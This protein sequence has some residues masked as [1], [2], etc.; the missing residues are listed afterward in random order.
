MKFTV[1]KLFAGSG[2]ST[3]RSARIHFRN[4]NAA[5]NSLFLAALSFSGAKVQLEVAWANPVK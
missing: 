5:G 2:P 1:I 3:S 4:N